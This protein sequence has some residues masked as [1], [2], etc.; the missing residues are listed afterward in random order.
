MAP[1]ARGAR[2]IMAGTLGND[3][4]SLVGGLNPSVQPQAFAIDAGGRL[5]T[6]NASVGATEAVVPTSATL[7]GA[8]D[9]AGNLEELL[10]ES[11]ANPNLRIAVFQG[12]NQLAIS[13]AG[14]A[15]VDNSAFYKSA[16]GTLTSI[17]S[18]TTPSTQLLAANANRKGMY[19]FNAS[20]A[21]LFLSFNA[22]ATNASYT[23]QIPANSFFEMPAT[24]VY[25]GIIAGV[26]AAANGSALIT[27]MS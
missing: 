16:T 4:S 6:S 9:N 8:N 19:V 10:L 17:A 20:T 7:L 26:W 21:I 13:A 2:G 27:E 25:T 14:L 11:N 12:A 1:P 3:G 23:V 22:T 15:S 5:V 18:T 24:P